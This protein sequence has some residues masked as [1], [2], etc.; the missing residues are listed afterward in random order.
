MCLLLLI[1]YIDPWLMPKVRDISSD[2]G[3]RCQGRGLG[4]IPSGPV[5]G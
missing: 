1:R 4:I 2:K 5:Y 3:T